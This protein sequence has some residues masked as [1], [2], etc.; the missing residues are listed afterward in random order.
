MTKTCGHC[1]A[2]TRDRFLCRTCT[3][4]LGRDL[5]DVGTLAPELETSG[6]KAKAASLSPIPTRGLAGAP[7]P[8]WSA[9]DARSRLTRVLAAAVAYSRS[10][11]YVAAA[12]TIPVMPS[13]PALA[14]LLADPRVLV[15]L[16]GDPAGPDISRK[17]LVAVER[18]RRVIDTRPA[19]QY[20]G[21][22]DCGGPLYAE[23]GSD[24][25]ACR[26]CKAEQSADLRRSALL[27]ELEGRLCT[28]A[29][30]ADLSTHLGLKADR[31]QVRKRINSWHRRGRISEVGDRFRFGEVWHLLM[32]E[33]NPRP[34]VTPKPL[35]VP[36]S[37]T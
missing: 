3:E 21:E 37:S 10:K 26:D 34:V 13:A 20:L 23:L 18:C 15:L 30:I 25:A 35:R 8:D 12:W 29:E 1:G 7:D 24:T 31:E 6:A 11:G 28:A 9:L 16:A 36:T 2:R 17:V 32:A 19:R 33:E 27:A 14:G 4:S 5:R 22:C